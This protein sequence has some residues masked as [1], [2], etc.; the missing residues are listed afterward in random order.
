VV[1]VEAQKEALGCDEA[2]CLAEMG[3]ALGARYIVHGSM[4]VLGSTTVV[5]LS[6]FDSE[7]QRAVARETIETKVADELLPGVRRALEKIRVRMLGASPALAVVEEPSPLSTGLLVGG[8]VGALG[9]AG[10]VIGGVMMG[11][12]MGDF[13]DTGADPLK[14]EAAQGLGQAGTVVLAAG[15]VVAGA[16]A[17]AFF[18][19]E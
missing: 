6:L 15:A 10:V 3:Q 19:L 17:G 1:S 2:S 13:Y 8:G 12:A 5:Q 16:G 9:A 7:A 11:L 4:G 14:R 18:L